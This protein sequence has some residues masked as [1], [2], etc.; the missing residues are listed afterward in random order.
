MSSPPP[1]PKTSRS[2]RNLKPQLGDRPRDPRRPPIP[3]WPGGPNS[4]SERAAPTQD[5]TD[6]IT[7]SPNLVLQ[8]AGGGGE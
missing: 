4:A 3:R 1:Q 5:R 6:R 8:S 2:V 7:P